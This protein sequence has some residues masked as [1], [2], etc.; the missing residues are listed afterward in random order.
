[1][2]IPR[3][4]PFSPTFV[5]LIISLCLPLLTFGHDKDEGLVGHWIF[6]VTHISANT[7]I[8]LAGNHDAKIE[9]PVEFF[10]K[11][12]DRGLCL[13]PIKLNRQANAVLISDDGSQVILPQKEITVEAYLRLNDTL[14]CNS[15]TGCFE[16]NIKYND[17]FGWLLGYHGHRFFFAIASVGNENSENKV[18]YLSALSSFENYKWYHVVGVYDG[19]TQQIYVNGRLQNSCTIQSGDIKY[20]QGTPY[21]IGA[22][23]DSDES[24]GCD[25]VIYEIK[26]HNVALSQKDIQTRYESLP[27]LSTSPIVKKVDII[28]EELPSAPGIWRHWS[29]KEGI[30]LFF[31][32]MSS[33]PTNSLL[34]GARSCYF[35]GYI[36]YPLPDTPL[37]F[38]L[39]EPEYFFWAS[40]WN[41]KSVLRTYDFAEH[42]LD[43]EW[44]EHT[45]I[46]QLLFSAFGPSFVPLD[47]Y[48]MIY[49]S[50][51]QRIME[52]TS[53]NAVSTPIKDVT[54]TTLGKFYN[55]T[56]GQDRKTIWVSAQDGIACFTCKGVWEEFS[57]PAPSGP[58]IVETETQNGAV[59]GYTFDGFVEGIVFMGKRTPFLFTGNG[60]LLDFKPD[61]VDLPNIDLVQYDP[62]VI[63]HNGK[64]YSGGI[65][66]DTG[67]KIDISNIKSYDHNAIWFLSEQGLSR[68]SSAIWETPYELQNKD[69]IAYSIIQDSSNR[70][71]ISYDGTLACLHNNNEWSFENNSEWG[72]KIAV[73]P[74]GKI[75]TNFWSGVVEYEPVTKQVHYLFNQQ[76]TKMK[77]RL[78]GQLNRNQLW[79]WSGESIGLYDGT[80]YQS[81]ISRSNIPGTNQKYNSLM[82]YGQEPNFVEKLENE[83]LW[84]GTGAGLFRYL[85]G[86]RILSE[87]EKKYP[88]SSAKTMLQT[89]DKK[90]WIS[91]HYDI[92]QFNGNHWE[93]LKSGLDRI[94]VM[95]QIRDGS[96]WVGTRN[97]LYIY[98]NG[99][100]IENTIQDDLPHNNINDIF[101]DN[102][103]RIWVATRKGVSLYH[104]ENDCDP[105]ETY[106]DD[107]GTRIYKN[108]VTE[109]IV[110]GGSI[111]IAFTGVD[112]WK[113][114]KTD[115]LLYSHRIDDNEWSSFTSHTVVSVTGMTEG[116]HVFQVRAM[117]RNRNIDSSP[118]LYSLIVLKPWYRKPMFLFLMTL[119]VVL[120]ILFACYALNRHMKL[121]HSLS[122]LRRANEQLRELDKMKSVFVSQASHDLRTPLTA[123]KSSMDNLVRG[124]GGGLNER[125]QNVVTRA[126]RSVNRLTVLIN[127]ILDI[128]RIESGRVVLDKT[129]ISFGSLVRNAIH[130][131]QPAADQKR[132]AI[133]TNNLDERYP[134]SVDVGKMERVVGELISNAIKYTPDGG[135]IEVYLKREDNKVIFEVKDTGIGM[136]E[137]EREKIWERFYRTKSSQKFA[138]GSGLGLS[139]AKELMEMHEGTIIVQS[140]VGKGTTFTIKIPC[141]CH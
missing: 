87:D 51:D 15:I 135:N 44:N 98:W 139:I 33:G 46:P 64:L 118:A 81:I 73:L 11:E 127:D 37:S 93:K 94:N 92:Y 123:I 90:I 108:S 107:N 105:P 50:N 30:P 32:Q 7:V 72:S 78:I 9:F 19:I 58:Y 5:I 56:L 1:M 109:E 77:N 13:S 124:V 69:S 85:H 39:E 74:N 53:Q 23:R 137:E 100:W 130:E 25:G 43:G 48:R 99:S 14:Y 60:F 55:L 22:Y 132:I 47:K 138:K 35:D 2:S 112:K 49:I 121:G 79:L 16:D 57:S 136:A 6:D 133:Q 67:E 110:S 111:R 113:M 8:D 75:V 119:S 3:W 41:D 29:R 45:V 122:D 38:V 95:R 115:R 27:Q 20:L 86:E 97:G 59:I 31:F 40:D 101:Q 71:W 120:I 84:I 117:D 36:V 82:Y 66:S 91:S 68:Y 70:I 141:Q 63:R 128:N 106:I 125:Q 42:K 80:Q 96:I 89:Q 54:N 24:R 140:E 126:L 134:V 62:I 34:T 61:H 18:T 131:N 17:G 83:E 26:V 88:G 104:P 76:N 116:S 65:D 28:A 10:D 52:Y 114:T 129:E 102:Q 103:G 12:N 21:V 4:N